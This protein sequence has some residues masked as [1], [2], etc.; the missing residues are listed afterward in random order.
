MVDTDSTSA[1]MD[2]VSPENA[3]SESPC[4]PDNDSGVTKPEDQC[5]TVENTQEPVESN[6]GADGPDPTITEGT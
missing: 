5:M 2:Q 6:Q 3:S 1:S 4:V